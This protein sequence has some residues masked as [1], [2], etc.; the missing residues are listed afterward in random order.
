MNAALM[1][2]SKRVEKSS[3]V[4]AFR[5]YRVVFAYIYPDLQEAL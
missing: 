1:R 2:A 5:F 4:K 3:D